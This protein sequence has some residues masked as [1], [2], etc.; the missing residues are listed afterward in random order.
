MAAAERGDD[1]RYFTHPALRGAEMMRAHFVD[2]VF[3]RHS[4]D[5]YALGVIEAGALGFRYRGERVVAHEGLVNLVVPGEA[6]DG[7]AAVGQGWRYRMFYLAPELLAGAEADAGGRGRLPH[8]AAGVLR[9]PDLAR[10]IRRLHALAEERRAPDLAV[11]ELFGALLVDWIARHAETRPSPASA[12]RE[13]AAVRRARELLHARFAEGVSLDELAAAAG[14]SPFHLT[15]TFTAALG[16]PPHAYQRQL[17]L[18][19]ARRLL[20]EA[21][22][23]GLRL[24]DVAQETGFAD[25]SHLTRA[26]RDAFGLTPGAYR[27]N[28][29]NS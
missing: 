1:L 9:D 17:R 16:L 14:L 15:R 11:R 8:F 18:A 3:A 13:P 25:Q 24:A 19:Q 5:C 27:K 10:R 26:F 23:A 2:R 4:H 28:V 21:P 6:H 20:R 22:D 12:G 7:Q 29:Q